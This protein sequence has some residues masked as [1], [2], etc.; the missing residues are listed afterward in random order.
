MNEDKPVSEV[1][2][3]AAKDLTGEVAPQRKLVGFWQVREH[4][5]KDVSE[6]R[7]IYFGV[8]KPGAPP[9]VQELKNEIDR[10][11][12]TLRLIYGTPAAQPRFDEAF[13]RLLHLAKVGL[14][15]EKPAVVEARAALEALKT[16]IVNREGGRIKNGY[17]LKL[18]QWALGFALVSLLAYFVC[19]QHPSIP[20]DEIYRYRRA[21]LVWSGCMA[22]A[23][24]SFAARKVV[25]SF[26]DL[27]QLEEDRLDPALRLVFVG[28]LTMFLVLVFATGFANVIVGGFSAASLLTSGSTAMLV[29]AL[30]GL[31]EQALPAA[32][33]E[34]ARAVVDGLQ[35]R[36]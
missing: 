3:A 17:M 16:E 29:G 10:T 4:D 21:F 33:M 7:D 11:L 30:A 6:P 14:Q 34:R 23:W 9:E 24:A 1:G 28:V 20:P 26:F 35:R 5:R 13:V 27:A 25:L 19:D 12:S 15:G 36:S 22:G 18:G 8:I 31:S 32:M 2:K